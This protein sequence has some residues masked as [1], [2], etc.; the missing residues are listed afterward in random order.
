MGESACYP[1]SS[2]VAFLR[3]AGRGHVAALMSECCKSAKEVQPYL[4]QFAPGRALDTSRGWKA[5]PPLLF[6]HAF[7]PANEPGGKWWDA[8]HEQEDWFRIAVKLAGQLHKARPIDPRMQ[9]RVAAAASKDA[10]RRED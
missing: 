6:S 5:K 9:L 4:S 3:R 2:A 8:V 10:A 1:E 7:D